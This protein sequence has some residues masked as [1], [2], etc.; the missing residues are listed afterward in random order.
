MSPVAIPA[1][2]VFTDTV[3]C[4]PAI[5][6]LLSLEQMPYAKERVKQSVKQATEKVEKHLLEHY[7][8]EMVL[9]M[10]EKLRQLIESVNYNSNKKSVALYLSPLLEKIL[11]LDIPVNEAVTVDEPWDIR[12]IV[13]NKKQSKEYLVV[14]L[15]EKEYKI[16]EGKESLLRLILHN[17][18]GAHYAAYP[19][20][21]NGISADN[22]N[23]TTEKELMQEHFLQHAAR[24]LEILLQA[25]HL[26]V[27][28]IGERQSLDYFQK[29]MGHTASVIDCLPGHRDLTDEEAIS[30]ILKPYIADWEKVRYTIIQ[31]QLKE[32][33]ENQK[34]VTGI[35]SVWQDASAHKGNLLVVERNFVYPAEPSAGSGQLLA[36]CYSSSSHITNLVDEIIEKI[37]ETGGDVMFVEDGDL[38]CYEG[39]A[40]IQ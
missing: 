38:E 26:P 16:Y 36:G 3:P 39:I 29:K 40:L 15:T 33:A 34:L 2:H 21:L 9:L 13:F 22:H 28:V 19:S 8:G 37:L 1:S 32:A 12:E 31:K 10:K 35:K 24:T 25:Y 14:Q 23:T 4:R 18:T 20:I 30:K 11:Y 27:F 5:S 7:P 17:S 6:V